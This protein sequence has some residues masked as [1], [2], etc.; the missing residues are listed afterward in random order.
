MAIGTGSGGNDYGANGKLGEK[1]LTGKLHDVVD[2][3]SDK[4]SDLAGRAKDTFEVRMRKLG[5]LIVARP[6]GSVLIAFGVGYLL[7]K[8]RR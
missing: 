3:A 8:L 2:Q 7:A 4:A 6:I 1:N 5:D